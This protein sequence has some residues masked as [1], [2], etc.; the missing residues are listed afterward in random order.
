MA[1]R[2]QRVIKKAHAPIM[3]VDEQKNITKIVFNE[4]QRIFKMK[5]V[6]PSG[7]FN[8]RAEDGSTPQIEAGREF[9]ITESELLDILDTEAIRQGQACFVEDYEGYDV[10]CNAMSD[11]KIKEISGYKKKEF[12]DAIRTIDSELTFKRIKDILI[13]ENKPASYLQFVEFHEKG[14]REKFLA[15]QK[16]ETAAQRSERILKSMMGG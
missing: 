6:L 11:N 5:N 9:E 13:D 14:L 10:V 2:P 8:F 1:Q 3:G 16:Y 4:E 12:E 7:L 15:E